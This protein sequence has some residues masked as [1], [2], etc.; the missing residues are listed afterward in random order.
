M[1]QVIRFEPGIAAVVSEKI[2]SGCSPDTKVSEQRM[3]A[4]KPV[5]TF[6]TSRARAAESASALSAVVAT[7][8]TISFRRVMASS[9]MAHQA[10]DSDEPEPAPLRSPDLEIGA[11]ETLKDLA[12]SET[13]GRLQ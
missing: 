6:G 4:R 12:D 8:M 3:L 2:R 9:G 1:A 7:R 13:T 11:A 5:A 10:H